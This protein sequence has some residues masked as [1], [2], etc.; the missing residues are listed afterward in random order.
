E[1]MIA[2]VEDLQQNGGGCGLEIEDPDSDVVLTQPFVPCSPIVPVNGGQYFTNGYDQDLGLIAFDGQNLYL[3]VRT[4]GI[5][6]DPDGNG[7]PDTN[8]NTNIID[9]PGIGQFESYKWFIDTNC[10]GGPDILVVLNNN[11]VT[12]TGTTFTGATYAYS[13][14]GVEVLV[15][16]VSL[17]PQ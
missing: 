16:G 3:G 14:H 6:R 11:K 4:V 10:D 7:N 9:N 5:A 12:V 2:Y 13:G 1:D 17:V 15:Q 8:C